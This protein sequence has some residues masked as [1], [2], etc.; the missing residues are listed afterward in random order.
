MTIN[1]VIF[2]L[3]GT[4]VDSAPGILKSF[5]MAFEANGILPRKQLTQDLIGPPLHVALAEIAE[6]NDPTVLRALAASFKMNYDAVGYLSARP[7]PGVEAL[8]KCLNEHKIPL[9]IATNKR[10]IPTACIIESLNWKKYFTGVF[11]LD[12]L[13]PPAP[14]K[15]H[16]IKYITILFGLNPNT[17]LYVGDRDADRVAANDA[18][19]EFFLAT[20]GYE[21]RAP[22][23]ITSNVGLMSLLNLIVARAAS[24]V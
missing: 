3:D 17:T 2:D 10:E 1:A 11:S 5:Q 15:A 4:L 16:L 9:Y 12:S 20:W 24:D 7:F 21:E 13:T 18:M 19:T 22:I 8:L 14:T 23:V 6:T